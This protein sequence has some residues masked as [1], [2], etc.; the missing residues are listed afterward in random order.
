MP[1]RSGD[2]TKE[3]L[4]AQD[5]ELARLMNEE[6]NGAPI[7]GEIAEKMTKP[8]PVEM[9]YQLWVEVRGEK[10]P[11]AIGPRMAYGPLEDLL[12]AIN[13]QIALGKEKRWGNPLILPCLLID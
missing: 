7:P 3:E 6:R 13:A 11:K 9:L 8:K 12:A 5:A 2:L 1:T 4:K 10:E